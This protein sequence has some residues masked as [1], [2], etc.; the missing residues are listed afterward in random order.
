[1][2]ALQT[3]AQLASSQIVNCLALGIA[4]T[5]VAGTASAMAGRKSPG[6]RFAIWFAALLAIACLFLAAGPIANGTATAHMNAISLRPEWALYIFGTWTFFAAI[7]LARVGRGLWRVRLLKQRSDLLE[8][9]ISAT[10]SS[11]LPP[12]SR[13]FRLCVSEQLRVPAALGFFTPM[14][15]LPAWAVRELSAQELKTIVLHEA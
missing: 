15:V 1:M 7:G 10:I 5:A 11:A 8:P 6:M 3:M 14:I 4:I 9:G 12:M 13:R 2:S